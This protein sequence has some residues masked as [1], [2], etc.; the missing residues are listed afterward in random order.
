MNLINVL[1]IFYIEK[2]RQESNTT[3]ELVDDEGIIHSNVDAIMDM[4]YHFYSNLYSCVDIDCEKK[5]T[6]LSFVDKF[7]ELI[8]NE[9]GICNRNVDMLEIVHAL[10]GMANN[11][12]PGSDGLT[13]EFYRTFLP[14]LKD[15]LYKLYL[16]IENREEMSHSMKIGVITLIYKK[17]GDKRS[18]KNWR[19]IS[20]LNVDYKIIARIMSN[21]LKHVHVLPNIVSENQTC[22]IVGRDIVDTLASIRDIIDLV[23]MEKMEGYIL[24]IDQEKAFDRVSHEYLLDVLETFGFGNRFKKWVQIFYTDIHSSVKSNGHLTKYFPIKNSVR[25]GCPISALLY[26]LASEP[27]SCAIR[28]NKYIR[29]KPISMSKKMHYYSSMLMIQNYQFVIKNQFLKYFISLKCTRNPLVL[30]SEIMCIGTGRIC[31]EDKKL[32]SIP[33][34]NITTILGIYFGRN[35]TECKN[36]NWRDKVQEIKQTLNL[37]RQRMLTIHGR[38]TVINSLLMSKLWY[39]LSVIPIPFWARDSIQKE[40]INLFWKCGVHLLSYKTAVVDR[41]NGG[42]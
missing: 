9:I 33:E 15:I 41:K 35:K 18:L 28:S 32:L 25:Q 42:L 5:N 14:Q 11:K 23:E 36:F 34:A 29:G 21:R 6:F 40:C 31:E 30:K 19:P 7:K 16:E 17:R 22:C 12:S 1:N 26:V 13:V 37:W 24:K 10:K 27:L 38:V 8:E 20:L 39:S 2:A 4:Q 3:K